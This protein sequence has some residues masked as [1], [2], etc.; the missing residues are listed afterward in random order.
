MDIWI[1]NEIIAFE[2]LESNPLLQL[3]R[4]SCGIERSHVRIRFR[5][6]G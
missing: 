3:S 4:A 6:E 2:I 1:A 5:V